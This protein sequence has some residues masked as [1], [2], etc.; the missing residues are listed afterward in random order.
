MTMIVP[1]KIDDALA[2]YTGGIGAVTELPTRQRVWSKADYEDEIER[3][4][5]ELIEARYVSQLSE[6]AAV[7][8]RREISNLNTVAESRAA[9]WER[10]IW[11]WQIATV[12]MGVALLMVFGSWSWWLSR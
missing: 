2:E 6:Q 5:I 1:D 8:L 12:S 11:S 9:V 4:T 7:T 3:L 10:E